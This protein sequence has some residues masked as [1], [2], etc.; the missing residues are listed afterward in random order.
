MAQ[1]TA[2]TTHHMIVVH[3]KSTQANPRLVATNRARTALGFQHRVVLR[4]RHPVL[5]LE[6]FR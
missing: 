2:H 5:L 3:H 6:Q 4:L 1:Q